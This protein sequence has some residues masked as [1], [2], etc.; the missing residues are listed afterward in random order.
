MALGD[1]MILLTIEDVAAILGKSVRT[2]KRR[3]IPYS[4]D[5]A[6]RLYDPGHSKVCPRR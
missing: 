2:V 1:K 6:T 3:P 5:G 4:R